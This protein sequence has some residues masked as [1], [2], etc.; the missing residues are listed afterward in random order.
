MTEILWISN[1]NRILPVVKYKQASKEE[2]KKRE[3]LRRQRM[4]EQRRKEIERTE[5]VYKT[6]CDG[7]RGVYNFCQ[8]LTKR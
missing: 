4:K 3:N 6:L 7:A 1:K 5:F 8:K 2:L